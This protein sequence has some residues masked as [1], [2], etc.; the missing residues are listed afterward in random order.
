M[1]AI[2]EN[3]KV[4]MFKKMRTT[5]WYDVYTSI[6][7][8]IDLNLFHK[9]K[10]KLDKFVGMHVKI[11]CA[12]VVASYLELNSLI[13]LAGEPSQWQ[14]MNMPSDGGYQVSSNSVSVLIDHF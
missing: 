3:G 7:L 13:L 2:F 8:C 1:S 11:F 12:C 6:T 4:L 9:S 5:L 10:H 14:N